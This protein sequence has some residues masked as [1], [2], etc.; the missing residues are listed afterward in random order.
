MGL[1]LNTILL[2]FFLDFFQVFSSKISVFKGTTY[3]KYN[4]LM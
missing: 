4:K 1:F 2:P 3:N